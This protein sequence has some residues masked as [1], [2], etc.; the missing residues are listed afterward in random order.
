MNNIDSFVEIMASNLDAI[1]NFGLVNGTLD[2]SK[3]GF[4]NQL[5]FVKQQ[6]NNSQVAQGKAGSLVQGIQYGNVP[7]SSGDNAI[8][9]PGGVLPRGK[10][11]FGLARDKL[12]NIADSNG[13]VWSIGLMGKS[14][15]I[16]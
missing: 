1:Y 11:M 10:V 9:L 3:T 15:F 6:V 16:R 7:G 12:G 2:K 13:C 14:T 4:Q 5:D 8:K